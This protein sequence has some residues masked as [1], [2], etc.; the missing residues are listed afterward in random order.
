MDARYE[1]VL[2]ILAE[3]GNLQ[4]F[5]KPVQITVTWPQG[6]PDWFGNA[7]EVRQWARDQLTEMRAD[8]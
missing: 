8:G 5:G 3:E 2:A 7:D 6:P 1:L 4:A